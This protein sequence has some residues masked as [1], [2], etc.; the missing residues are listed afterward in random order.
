MIL[1]QQAAVS[2]AVNPPAVLFIC[3]DDALSWH[4]DLLPQLG[5]VSGP[6]AVVHPVFI[7][8]SPSGKQT[9]WCSE[10]RWRSA[11]AGKPSRCRHLGQTSTTDCSIRT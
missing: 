8:S 5:Q 7:L 10:L 3:E 2:R 4:E 9:L 11:L 1:L 6:R